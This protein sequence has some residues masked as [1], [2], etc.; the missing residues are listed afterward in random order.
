MF[1]V[2]MTIVMPLEVTRDLEW[3]P[4]DPNFLLRPMPWA[5][6]AAMVRR[7]EQALGLDP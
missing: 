7:Q 4:K 2:W 5:K 1:D 3:L 6:L